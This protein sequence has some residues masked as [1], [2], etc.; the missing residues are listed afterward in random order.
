M[1]TTDRNHAL[2]IGAR[3]RRVRHQQELSLADVQ[4]RSN[5]Q[6]KAV[7][8]GAYER[9]DR[10]VTVERLADLA[11]FYDVPL[12]DLLPDPQVIRAISAGRITLDL[13]RLN[14][15]TARPELTVLARYAA[16]VARR[17]GD[18]NG[19]VL[20]LRAGDLETVALVVDRTAADLKD[21]LE[22]AEVLLHLDLT[23]DLVATAS[24]E[25][26]PQGSGAHTPS[27][28]QPTLTIDLREGSLEGER[29]A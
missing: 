17:R 16:H 25:G 2:A 13:V 11:S 3:L 24:T 21:L 9:G 27:A 22:D 12:A 8:V 5:G 7:V 26:S 20:T 14:A 23:G 29:R 6:W 19:R 4:A 28:D 1:T 15:A 18:H 10:S